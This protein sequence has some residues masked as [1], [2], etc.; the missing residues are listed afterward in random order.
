MRNLIMKKALANIVRIP[1]TVHTITHYRIII[2]HIAQAIKLKPC[3]HSV[4][5]I[6][7]TSIAN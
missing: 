1:R 6:K 2:T 5:Y 3:W 7:G 4:F